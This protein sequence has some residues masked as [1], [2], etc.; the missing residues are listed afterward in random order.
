MRLR[1][2]LLTT[3]ILPILPIV[4]D[5][6]QDPDFVIWF[7][8]DAHIHTD[9]RNGYD[10]LRA[11]ISDTVHGGDEGGEAINWNIAVNHGDTAGGQNCKGAQA[12][13]EVIQQIEQAGV[14]PNLIYSIIGNHDAGLIDNSWFQTYL[15]PAGLTPWTSRISNSSR[16]Y[17][18]ENYSAGHYSFQVGN[19]LFLMLMDQNYGGPPFGRLC[20][21][22]YPAGRYLE[23]TYNW[24]VEMVEAHQDLNIITVAHHALMDTTIHTE[25]GAGVERGIHG[26]YSWADENGS[27]FIYA[28]GDWTIDGYN[29]QREFIGDRPFGFRKYLEENPGAIDIWI[30]GHTHTRLFPG[31]MLEGKSDIERVDDVLFV[32]AGALTR[33]HGGPAVPFSRFL[34]L[35]NES[36]QAYLKTYIHTGDWEAPEG[37]YQASQLLIELRHEFEYNIVE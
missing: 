32:N 17:S 37:I 1:M 18:V 14:D 16:Q 9:S 28:I 15:D 8:G 2:L 21:G 31:Q 36:N 13:T 11:S 22:G 6:Q 3:M 29:S 24:W 19:I 5:A 7:F 12:G 27:S 35:A 26:N 10:S 33:I 23:E 20:D 25:M 4:G 30:H 34:E